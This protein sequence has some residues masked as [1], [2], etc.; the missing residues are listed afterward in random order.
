MKTLQIEK[1]NLRKFEHLIGKWI[2]ITGFQPCIIKF[3]GG[4]NDDFPIME[5][6]LSDGRDVAVGFFTHSQGLRTPEIGY[7]W[8]CV[9]VDDL[10]EGSR[11]VSS[12]KL[13]DRYNGLMGQYLT[14]RN[15]VK[16]T[17]IKKY[18]PNNTH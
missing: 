17:D 18:F 1:F 9:C 5:S 7:S 10:I 4:E 16:Y 14:K 15:R 2:M 13:A 6:L 3:N 8:N 11:I 12:K